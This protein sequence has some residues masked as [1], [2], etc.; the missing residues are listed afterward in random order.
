MKTYEISVKGIVQ[1][2]GFRPFVFRCAKKYNLN[3]FIKN[4]SSGVFILIQ[5]DEKKIEDF[6]NELNSNHPPRAKIISIERKII[7]YEEMKDFRIIESEK[8]EIVSTYISPDIATCDDCLKELFDKNDRRYLYPFI[9]C[10]NC[11][12]RFTITFG[13]PYDRINTTMSIFKMCD[14]CEDEY[15][16]PL[17]RRFHAQ[18]NACYKCGPEV[19]LLDKNLERISC[20]WIERTIEL[21]NKGKI[22]MIKGIG[23]YHIACDAY[24]SDAVKEVRKRKRRGNKPFALMGNIEMIKENCYLNECEER[25]LKSPQAPIVLLKKREDSKIPEEVAPGTDE[26]GFM[27]PYTPLHHIII[28]NINFPILLTSANISEETILYEDERIDRLKDIFDYVLT[29]NRKI[30][31]WNEDSVVRCFKGEIYPIRISRGFVPEP[32]K[33]PIFSDKTILG[34]GSDLK[35]AFCILKGDYAF[36]SQYIGDMGNIE[37]EN[38]FYKALEH[39]KRI[40][41]LNIDFAVCDLHPEY[42]TGNIISKIGIPHIKVQHHRAHFVSCLL[43]NNILDDAIGF[44]FDG[45]GYGEDNN[46]WGGEVFYGNIFNQERIYHLNYTPLP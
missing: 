33:V 14:E 32:F 23:G 28:K 36:T 21:L 24:N 27:L 40:Y 38:A 12:P 25:F 41:S 7:D 46:I 15:E 42:I 44:I 8:K 11:G 22:L 3:G 1:G 13:I 35:N 26:L 5:G 17:S 9:N 20:D 31:I 34:A 4:D 6:L 39:F 30:F 37:T 16:D 10:T 18:P 19:F 29:H 45:T 2:V 43:E